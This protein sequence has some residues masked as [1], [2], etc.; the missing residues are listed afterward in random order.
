MPL[1]ETSPRLPPM[2]RGS[3]VMRVEVSLPPVVS[4]DQ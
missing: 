2:S 4:C 1:T 3:I